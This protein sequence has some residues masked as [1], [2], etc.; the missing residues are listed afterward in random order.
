MEFS[1]PERVPVTREL[2]KEEVQDAQIG[3]LEWELEDRE[4][5]H[6]QALKESEERGGMDSL[7]GLRRREVLEN[8]LEQ[9]LKVIRGE[10]K[11]Q[12]AGA[13]AKEVSL[14]AIDLD[15]F[16]TVND[17][18]G[19][20]AGDEA[21]RQVATLLTHSVR[22]M[23]VI[24]RVGGEELMVL[25][26]NADAKVAARH[27]EDLRAKIEKIV[28]DKYP[29]LHLTASFGVVSSKS[30]ADAKELYE[31]A[32]KALYAAKRGG[33]NRVEAYKD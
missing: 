29:G 27:A 20:G 2:A 19:H 22:G 23:D 16:K 13:E 31:Y 8:E 10:T 1:K 33:R 7:T 30:S 6:A 12:R 11:E 9:S 4:E 28:F 21:L 18:Y 14:I 17:T 25:M 32:D 26:R 5:R 15:H 24:A 3:L